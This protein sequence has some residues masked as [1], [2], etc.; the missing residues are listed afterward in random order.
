MKRLWALWAIALLHCSLVSAKE[1]PSDALTKEEVQ[2]LVRVRQL[3]KWIGSPV[4]LSTGLCVQQNY[5]G[6]WP[7]AGL[8]N[9]SL[10]AENMLQQAWETCNT[11][12]EGLRLVKQVR[13]L[14]QNQILRLTQPYRALSQCQKEVVPAAEIQSCLVSAFGRPLNEE[15]LRRLVNSVQH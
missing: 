1:V 4:A 11:T 2:S 13:E 8:N 14:L 15:E 10:R 6:A 9:I 5:A 3:S 12:G 7:Q